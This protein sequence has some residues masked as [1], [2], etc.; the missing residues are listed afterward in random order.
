MPEPEPQEVWQWQLNCIGRGYP[1]NRMPQNFGLLIGK[2][3]NAEACLEASVSLPFYIMNK[4]VRHSGI[5]TY[6]FTV[7]EAERHTSDFM[8]QT[9]AIRCV[10]RDLKLIRQWRGAPFPPE[11][12]APFLVEEKPN[13]YLI[14]DFAFY[15]ITPQTHFIKAERSNYVQKTEKET[16][17]TTTQRFY[18]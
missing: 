17:E 18:A 9:G 16:K 1:P 12:N 15:P 13:P 11:A 2:E 6:E 7:P 10:S 14:N 3:A 8:I 4:T 5:R